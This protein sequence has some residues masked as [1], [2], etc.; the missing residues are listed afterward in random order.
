MQ[1]IAVGTIEI[2]PLLD[3]ALIV[4]MQREAAVVVDAGAFK[5]ASLNLERVVTTVSGRI[6]PSADGKPVEGGVETLRP[7]APIGL[8]APDIGMDVVG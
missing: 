4:P 5:A 7:I 8:D 6:E 1:H 3:D 2:E